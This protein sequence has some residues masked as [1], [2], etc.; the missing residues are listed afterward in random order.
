MPL[1]AVNI[2]TYVYNDAWKSQLLLPSAWY[3]YANEPRAKLILFTEVAVPLF[4]VS[5][6]TRVRRYLEKTFSMF[7]ADIFPHCVRAR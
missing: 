1:G 4:N 6:I 5:L 2:K 7:R 3:L